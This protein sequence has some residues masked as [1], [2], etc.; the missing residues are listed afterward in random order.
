MENSIRVLVVVLC[1]VISVFGDSAVTKQRTV[2]KLAE[3]VYEIRHP[4]APDTFPQSNTTV[5]IG[6]EAVLVVDS[7]Y[8]PSAA[9]ED[10][11]QIKKWTNKP[12]RYLLNTHWHF[13]H[14]M[15]N[16]A[17]AEAFPGLLIIAQR[18]TRNS[19]VGYNPGWFE[20]FP[21]RAEVFKKALDSGKDTN[22]NPLTEQD[23]KD[24]QTAIEG[25]SPVWAEYKVL[26][27]RTPNVVFDS[28]MDLDL[29][30]REVRLQFLGKGNTM[31]DAIAYLPKEKILVTGDLLVHPIPYLGG[32]F[33]TEHLAT[34][35]K[36][37][38]IDAETIVPGHGDVMH[39]KKFMY[40][41]T[42]LL[43][44]VVNEVR[45]QVFRLGN[46]SNNLEAVQKG[47]EEKLNVAEL[48]R[49]FAGDD[50]DNINMFDTFSWPGVIKAAYREA[51][52]R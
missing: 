11:A 4:D 49:S 28:E 31:G 43:S 20:R 27:D 46:S 1:A 52:G 35:K 51:W 42:D 26:K 44:Q 38:L 22:G 36:L 8:L 9:K 15:G 30:N 6:D 47:V 3:G 5:I 2:T 19:C 25:I 24:Y 33:P 40:Q 18:E 32:G 13:D 48:R 50:K 21:K 12:V 41:V 39:D 37:A 17:Y 14:T 45:A 29:G 16:A 34:L 10:I 7:T 23:R